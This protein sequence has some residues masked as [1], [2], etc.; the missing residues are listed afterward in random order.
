MIINIALGVTVKLM[1]F[2]CV[3]KISD[4]YSCPKEPR[5]TASLRPPQYF[6][7]KR[8]IRGFLRWHSPTSNLAGKQ[9]QYSY[10]EVL[11]YLEIEL[12]REWRKWHIERE[13]VTKTPLN[14]FLLSYVPPKIATTGRKW[15]TWGWNYLCPVSCMALSSMSE[16]NFSEF[17]LSKTT[18][19]ERFSDS[20]SC[21]RAHFVW[22][23][24]CPSY[25]QK[26]WIAVELCKTFRHFVVYLHHESV[27]SLLSCRRSF[28]CL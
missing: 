3:K 25:W 27:R 8:S 21:V 16:W 7:Q 9:L 4:C 28:G 6:I 18:A 15:L 23:V 12:A 24:A 17:L 1:V 26:L 2:K 11:V 20:F 14:F 5:R 22:Q 19:S 13:C 10:Y